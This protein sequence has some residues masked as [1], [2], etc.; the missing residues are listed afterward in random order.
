MERSNKILTQAVL[1]ELFMNIICKKCCLDWKE[2]EKKKKG[3]CAEQSIQEAK[4]PW[5]IQQREQ[6]LGFS[7]VTNK[8]I[9]RFPLLTYWDFDTDRSELKLN[10]RKVDHHHI[11]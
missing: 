6:V 4:I 2:G 10:G 11:K 9:W 7:Y 1:W 3:K 5:I 8:R